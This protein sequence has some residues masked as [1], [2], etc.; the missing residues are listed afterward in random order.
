MRCLNS[1]SSQDASKHEG[2][3]T[4]SNFKSQVCVCVVCV[5]VCV[6]NIFIFILPFSSVNLVFNHPSFIQEI[7][8]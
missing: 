7:F 2:L 5:C 3:S 8:D 1:K 6:C 4:E